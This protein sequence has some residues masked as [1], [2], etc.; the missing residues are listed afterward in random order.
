MRYFKYALENGKEF[1]IHDT[2]RETIEAAIVKSFAT[3]SLIV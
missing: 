2:L 3:F 1:V